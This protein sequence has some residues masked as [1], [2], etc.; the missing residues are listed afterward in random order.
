[1]TPVAHPLYQLCVGDR[2]ANDSS[3]WLQLVDKCAATG[4]DSGTWQRAHWGPRLFI[5]EWAEQSSCNIS[6]MMFFVVDEVIRCT[7][8]CEREKIETCS[9]ITV[10]THGCT[11]TYVFINAYNYVRKWVSTFEC[12]LISSEMHFKSAVTGWRIVSASMYDS[13]LVKGKVIFT[14]INMC[15]SN[16]ECALWRGPLHS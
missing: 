11:R 9:L 6:S 3:D 14:V 15:S 10:R 12:D 7:T 1:M 16:A 13:G 5:L 2:V 4:S 8:Q